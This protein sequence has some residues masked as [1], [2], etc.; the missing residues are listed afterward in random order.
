MDTISV[1]IFVLFMSFFSSFI[2]IW[3]PY[4]TVSVQGVLRNDVTYTHHEMIMFSEYPSSH[5]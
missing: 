1:F 4:S 3:L 5:I 2:H